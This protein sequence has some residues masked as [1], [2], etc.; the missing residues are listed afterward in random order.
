MAVSGRYAGR[1]TAGTA[2]GWMLERAVRPSRL[3]G[4][5][6]LRTGADGRIYVAQVAGSAITALNPDSGETQAICPIDG[7]VTSP[8]DIAFDSAGNL[9]ATEITL[10]RVSMLTPDGTYRVLHGD[11]PVANP[12]TVHQDRLFAGECRMGGRVFELDRSGGAHRQVL[13]DVPMPNAFEIGPD[14][15]LYMPVMATN[16]IWR[17]DPAGGPHEVIA[18]DLGRIRSNSTARGA[19]F[20]RRWPADRCCASTRRPARVTCWRSLPPASTIAHFWVTGCS[21]PPFPAK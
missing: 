8:D 18:G 10:N 6:G 20:P 14:G 7:P 17:V 1:D 2:R 15:M 12:I 21:S 3:F 13:A 11:M 16:E 4:A 5:N 9:Y 19:S